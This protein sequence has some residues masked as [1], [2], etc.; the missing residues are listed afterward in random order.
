VI[1]RIRNAIAAR[2]RLARKVGIIPATV[3]WLGLVELITSDVMA[4]LEADEAARDT[5][6][7]REAWRK[8]AKQ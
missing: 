5:E 1:D 7:L 6:Q 3:D 8:G 2:I 4:A